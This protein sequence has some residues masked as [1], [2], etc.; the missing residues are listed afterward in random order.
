MPSQ[1]RK[2]PAY[3]LHKPTGQAVVRIDGRDFYLGKHGTDASQE[4]YRR[5][6]AE[7]AIS[8]LPAASPSSRPTLGV[9][10]AVDE[11]VLAFWDRHVVA[12][13]VKNG[14]PTSEQDNIRQALRFLRKLYGHFPARDLG[15]Q[16][17]KA[18]RQAMIDSG[19]C[20]RL[21][22][23]DV[24]RIR[25]MYRWAV[26]HELVPVAV[27]QALR[28]VAGLRRGRSEAREVEPVG[29]V[30][31]AHVR[32]TLPFLSP[33][34]AAMVQVQL[35]TGARPGEVCGL[36][37]SDL[38]ATRDEVWLYRPSEHKTEHFERERVVMI[39][40]RAQTVLRPWLDR[41]PDSTCFSPSEVVEARNARKRAERRSPMTPS[42]ATRIRRPNPKRKP[43]GR[44][45][46]NA[47]RVAIQRACIKAGVPVWTPLQL[48]HNAATTIRALYGLEAAQVVLGHAK[49]DVTEVYAEKDLALAR[50][51][52]AEVG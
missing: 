47:Y 38:A 12:Y 8:P 35:L 39:G 42:Q 33:Q 19:R 32:D 25:G 34:V 50:R 7:W 44:Y 3:R 27:L 11:L 20:R 2:P 52:A 10:L 45:G 6:I 41:A 48:R 31:E 21:I 40:P 4:A 28:S 30:P 36:R 14:R 23:K 18:V 37:P 1:L 22:N 51:V 24:N 5:L 29:P 17:L 26:E 13:Y 15:P 49:A 9:A 46:R 43:G 16:A